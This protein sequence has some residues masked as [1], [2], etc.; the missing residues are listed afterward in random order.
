[1]K[2]AIVTGASS[3][4]GR[5]IT[6]MLVR[7]EFTVFGFARRFKS[8]TGSDDC[9][10][11]VEC[12]VTDLRLLE[13][14]VKTVLE[15]QDGLDLLVNNAGVGVFGP[16]EELNTLDLKAMLETNF[17]APILLTRLCLRALKKRRG[18]IVQIGSTSALKASPIGSAYA[19]S[20]AGSGHFSL[21]LF[22][23][24]RKSG[25]RVVTINPDMTETP[26][27]D[28]AS[29]GTHEDADSRLLPHEVAKAVETVLLQREGSVISELTIKPQRVQ[30]KKK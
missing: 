11:P 23:E 13:A 8:A 1:M 22:E 12:D 30:I 5:S 18:M 6:E 24:V 20:K 10:Q 26:F 15:N 21:S 3:G 14:R 7:Q 9:F 17:V 29:F 4:I 2:T 25:V 19:A 16:H 27:Y 28:Q